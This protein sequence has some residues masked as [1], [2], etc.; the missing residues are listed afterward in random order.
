MW[1]EKR[2][3]QHRVYYRNRER[4]VGDRRPA[5]ARVDHASADGHEDQEERPSNSENSRRPS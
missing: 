4:P 1:I 5:E 3:R 2:G